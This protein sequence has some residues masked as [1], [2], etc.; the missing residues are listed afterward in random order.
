MLGIILLFQFDTTQATADDRI[1]LWVNGV[2]ETSFQLA[3]YPLTT[4][5]VDYG[6]RS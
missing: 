4:Q 5:I 1:K 3:T 6:Y 2:Q